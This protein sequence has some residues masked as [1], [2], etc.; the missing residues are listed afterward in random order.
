MA[1]ELA[2]KMA[3]VIAAEMAAETAIEMN[4]EKAAEKAAEIADEMAAEM[5]AKMATEMATGMA[6]ASHACQ[7]QLTPLHLVP[8]GR[9]NYTYQMYAAIA[10]RSCAAIAR[11]HEVCI[12][13][14][15]MATELHILGAGI[16]NGH[17]GVYT[18]GQNGYGSVYTA[19]Q[20]GHTGI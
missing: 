12:R 5:A 19:G 18:A 7:I 3:A 16:R 20:N 6:R 8:S 11:C 17:G 15:S 10:L 2:A 13:Q 9:T 4:A 14:A 1:G